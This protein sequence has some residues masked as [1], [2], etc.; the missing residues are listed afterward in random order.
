[1]S[2]FTGL[3][4][5]H[6]KLLSQQST[7]EFRNLRKKMTN[8]LDLEQ[9]RLISF[10]LGVN[11]DDISGTTLDLDTK[12]RGL[13]QYTKAHGNINQLIGI[14]QSEHSNIEWPTLKNVAID[15]VEKFINTGRIE[16]AKISSLSEREQ[17]QAYLTYWAQYV[18]EQTG[19][20]PDDHLLPPIKRS[21]WERVP[22]SKLWIS[23]VLILLLLSIVSLVI[24]Q[25]INSGNVSITPSAVPDSTPISIV[26]PTFETLYETPSLASR[27][28]DTP[29]PSNTPTSTLTFTSTQTPTERPTNTIIPTNTSTSTPTL[30]PISCDDVAIISGVFTQLVEEN[31]FSFTGLE[32]A[33]FKC[34]GVY[35]LFYKIPPAVKIDYVSVPN[36]YAFFSMDISLGFDVTGY[37]EICVWVYAE[38]PDQ[39]F[40]LNLK[41]TSNGEDGIGITTTTVR[42]WEEH[43]VA[44]DGY[45]GVDL[46]SILGI[47]LSFNDAFGSV[48]ILVDDFELR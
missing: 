6:E 17:L 38:A 25:T 41:D 45:V 36:S 39:Q 9:L 2:A 28:T 26:S 35:D 11:L 16:S 33:T 8:H 27:E 4:L 30:G 20:K 7:K 42:A 31:P 29:V 43:C 32:N 12:T 14:L 15:E 22:A 21:F 1:M 24:W 34:Q 44:L 10:E 40:D 18:Y 46:N 47:T 5:I 23:I 19:V 13:I 48:N 37:K 3:Q